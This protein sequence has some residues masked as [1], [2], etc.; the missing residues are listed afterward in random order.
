LSFAADKKMTFGLQP[1][2]FIVDEKMTAINS[3]AGGK[4]ISFKIEDQEFDLPLLGQVNIYNALCAMAIAKSLGLKMA[5]IKQASGAMKNIPGRQEF[6]ETNKNFKVMVDYAFEPKAMVALYE[7]VKK[8]PHQKIIHV[9]GSA[10]GGRD[11]ARRPKLGLLAGQNADFVIVTNEDPYDDDPQMIIEQVA[12][13]ALQAGKKEGIDLWKILDRREAIKKAL[14]LAG[15]NDL[16]LITGKGSEQA[17]C[18]AGGRKIPWDDREVVRE[19]IQNFR[20]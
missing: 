19:E 1:Q 18:V 6:I 8:I 11:A 14:T 5:E 20:I 15:V 17:I 9:L 13:G 3:V 4:N 2:A 7:T 10:G 16:V 12:A